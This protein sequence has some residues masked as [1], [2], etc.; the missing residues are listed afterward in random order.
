MRQ[1]LRVPAPRR[2][3]SVLR[4]APPGRRR[5]AGC[6]SSWSPC[7]AKAR[8]SWPD[9]GA[10]AAATCDPHLALGLPDAR[11]RSDYYSSFQALVEGR[12]DDDDGWVKQIAQALGEIAHR[13]KA[14]QV[15][16]PL[17]V[18][19]HIDHRLS[20]EASLRAL[21]SGDGRNVFLYE[22]RPEAFV[23]G[24]V[25]VRLGQVGARLP[26]AAVHAADRA[27]LAPFVWRFHL[28]PTL[29]GDLKGWP[30][31]LPLD[32]PRRSA[33]AAGTGL[34]S[35]EGLRSAPAAGRPSHRARAARERA[36]SSRPRWPRRAQRP[37]GSR[38]SRPPTRAG[39]A[40]ASTPSGS[41]CCCRPA[42]KAASRR[43]RSRT[44]CSGS[45]RLVGAR[46]LSLGGHSHFTTV[47][48]RDPPAPPRTSPPLRGAAARAVGCPQSRALSP[49]Q[50]SG[51]CSQSVLRYVRISCALKRAFKASSAGAQLRVAQGHRVRLLL[52]DAVLVRQADGVQEDRRA[53]RG[54]APRWSA[55]R[56]AAATGSPGS[57]TEARAR[58]LL[59]RRHRPR[60]LRP[61]M[62]RL[63]DGAEGAAVDFLRRAPRRTGSRPRS[64]PRARA[65]STDVPPSLRTP[66]GAVYVPPPGTR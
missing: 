41:G 5:R 57:R 10:L 52:E 44:S 30:E 48:V 55:T 19:S 33:V 59:L 18:G 20:H 12:R 45:R 38:A 51:S 40:E 53:S 34:A 35:A 21:Q 61:E 3:A 8:A 2:R 6:A 66:F 26:P 15:Y 49:S 4:S 43:W 65:V 46:V 47:G 23:R 9:V 58:R 32:R 50:R 7:S 60:D 22:E 29:R 11:R 39:W 16:V 13:S 1:P 42:R 14:S 37:R 62:A 54:A 28:A 64:S 36:R 25:R 17:G 63:D 24:A 31:R 27:R 56:R